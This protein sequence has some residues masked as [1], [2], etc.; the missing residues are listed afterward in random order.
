MRPPW[1][2]KYKVADSFYSKLLNLIDHTYRRWQ[3]SEILASLP[4]KRKM[5]PDQEKENQN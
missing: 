5:Q 2:N 1:K 3:K 4:C